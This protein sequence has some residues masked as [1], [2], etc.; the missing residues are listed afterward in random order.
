[1]RDIAHKCKF[2]GEY[3]CSEHLLPEDH[4]CPGVKE[5]YNSSGKWM[6]NAS[7]KSKRREYPSESFE[8]FP[9]ITEKATSTKKPTIRK[10]PIRKKKKGFF[11]FIKRH[12][13]IIVLVIFF[14]GLISYSTGI[15]VQWTKICED[16]TRNGECSLNKPLYCSGETLIESAIQCGCSYGYKAS[17]NTCENI[18]T[19][20]GGIFY[21][22]CSTDKPFYCDDEG[23]LFKNANKCGC[24]P[25][26]IVKGGRCE[27]GVED[28]PVTISKPVAVAIESTSAEKKAIEKSSPLQPDIDIYELEREVHNL[29][30][31]ERIKNGLNPLSLDDKLSGVARSHSEDMAVNNYF[32]HTNLAG[33]DP[34][35]RANA[36]GYSC[37]KDFGSY[38]VTGI[39]ENIF[40]NNLYDSITYVYFVPVHEWNTLSEIAHSTVQGWMGSQ[41]HRE[42]ILTSTYDR[43]GIGVGI[44]SDDK[45]YITENFC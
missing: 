13:P 14:I 39:A 8:I 1:M 41:G 25:G 40:Q 32:S 30:N 7:R 11:G 23:R 4:K 38:Y 28:V 45:V 5:Y 43:E 37:Y 21:G 26:E 31:E 20:V 12:F 18:P 42:N 2:C 36:K 6:N 33:Q 34:T 3:H 10:K 44:S 22:E 35:G 29:I 17:G 19:C 27:P 15:P 24:P 16:G 9:T